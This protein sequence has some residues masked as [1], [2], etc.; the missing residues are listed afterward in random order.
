MA[1]VWYL[2]GSGY[3]SG[4]VL[5]WIS[6]MLYA[7]GFALPLWFLGH[8]VSFGLWLGCVEFDANIKC[9]SIVSQKEVWFKAMQGLECV[10]LISLSVAG[11]YAL[12][13]NCRQSI[14]PYHRYRFMEIFASL[15]GM[16][17]CISCM[18]FIF[19]TMDMNE[20]VVNNYSWG[21]FLNLIG[22]ILVIIFAIIIARYNQAALGDQA[23]AG[24]VI[25]TVPGATTVVAMH[26]GI[27]YPAPQPGPHPGYGYDQ[28]VPVT[29]QYPGGFPAPQ[30]GYA[31]PVYGGNN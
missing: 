13:V 1:I 14:L 20:S 21:F 15:G 6:F 29:A 7:I 12:F 25:Q 10:G 28:Q 2:R 16:C 30:A 22:S 23:T 8:Y 4:I 17:G 3:K 27:T 19:N 5:F 11:L 18:I 24:A 9:R 26:Q 31:S